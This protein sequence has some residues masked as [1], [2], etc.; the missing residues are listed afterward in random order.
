MSSSSYRV[1]LGFAERWTETGGCVRAI[2]AATGGASRYQRVSPRP[3]FAEVL[4]GR[5]SLSSGS[6]SRREVDEAR[7]RIL[8]G[9]VDGRLAGSKTAFPIVSLPLPRVG[10]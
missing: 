6:L 4:V 3:G 10:V 1:Y 5:S 2:L 8:G 9:L 7:P